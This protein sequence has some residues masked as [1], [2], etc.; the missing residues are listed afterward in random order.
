[1]LVQRPKP[2]TFSMGYDNQFIHES[3]CKSIFEA[4]LEIGKS[5][6]PVHKICRIVNHIVDLRGEEIVAE[7]DL[8]IV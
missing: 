6:T 5:M 3:I 2:F 4:V 7:H 8:T 1:M